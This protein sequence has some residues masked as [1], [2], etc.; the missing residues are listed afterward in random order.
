MSET[1]VGTKGTWSSNGYRFGGGASGRVRERGINPYVQEHIDLLESI[2]N[3]KP[4][5]ELQQVAESTM[6]AILGRLSAYT[7]KRLS[8]E[9][10]LNAKLDTFPSN[11]SWDAELPEAHV[12]MPGQYELS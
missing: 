7:G 2:V 1:L 10:A 12:A 4:L 11:V 9:E 5:N 3:G 6:T 8:W